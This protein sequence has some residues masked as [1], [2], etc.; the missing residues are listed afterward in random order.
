MIK[1]VSLIVFL[2]LI[3]VANNQV[4]AKSTNDE[5][6]FIVEANDTYSATDTLKNLRLAQ[7]CNADTLTDGKIAPGTSGNFTIS[8]ETDDLGA[9]YD[10][11]FDNFSNS[12]P[13]NLLFTVDGQPYDIQTGFHG[14]INN[15]GKAKHTVN[16][17]WEYEAEDEY[18]SE[19]DEDI[20]FDVTVKAESINERV[21]DVL[22]KTGF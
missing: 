8:I 10:I 3:L 7:T 11:I 19:Y 9:E 1:K 4:F 12:F 2:I 6:K 16:W 14:K 22:P 13:E 15:E 5:W 17:N 18:S 21:R 20:T